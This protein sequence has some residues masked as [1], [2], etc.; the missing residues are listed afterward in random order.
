MVSFFVFYFEGLFEKSPS[1]SPKTF[2]HFI[3]G[4]YRTY[5]FVTPWYYKTISRNLV[6]AAFR[7]PRA[8]KGRPYEGKFT[9]VSFNVSS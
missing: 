5:R 6:G 7:R 3:F 9:A 2:K 4:A 1:N 8:T